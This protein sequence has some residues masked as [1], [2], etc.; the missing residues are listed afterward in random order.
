MQNKVATTTDLQSTISI[1]GVDVEDGLY[2]II[3]GAFK[4][5]LLTYGKLEDFPITPKALDTERIGEIQTEEIY[6]RI[7]ESIPFVSNDDLRPAMKGVNFKNEGGKLNIAAT[8][9][10]ILYT[11]LIE[12]A[13]L[14]MGNEMSIV[15]P[16]PKLLSECLKVMSNTSSIVYVSYNK[17]AIRFSTNKVSILLNIID[18]AFPRYESVINENTN[19]AFIFDKIEML[20]IINSLKGADAKKNLMFDFSSNSNFADLKLFEV[21]NGK[22]T[23][24]KDLNV[25]IKYEIV[26]KS[27]VNNNNIG[28]LMPINTD[29]YN[30]KGFNP[31]YLKYIINISSGKL[32]LL[33]DSSK[34]MPQYVVNLDKMQNVG[35]EKSI[36]EIKRE[37]IEPNTSKEFDE[38][39]FE[40]IEP[41]DM[42]IGNIIKE[43]HVKAQLNKLIAGAT[44]KD[45]EAIFEDYKKWWLKN[46]SSDSK[47][48]VINTKKEEAQIGAEKLQGASMKEEAIA[49]IAALKY[50]AAKGN[51]EAIDTINSL[52]FLI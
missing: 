34:L 12:T 43:R 51:Q 35:Y 40:Q 49:T 25:K 10:H 52:K 11:A 28:L 22:S 30:A 18:E 15:L 48:V 7:T 9:M 20:K 6:K 8:N 23:V 39:V 42:W 17:S 19:K 26:D 32:E 3:N 2:Q 1:S 33:F 50:I 21:I 27:S 31:K 16:N 37:I 36:K 29:T 24:T 46:N 38:A 44:E 14:D 45:I 47:E 41:H 13:K 4:G 5:K